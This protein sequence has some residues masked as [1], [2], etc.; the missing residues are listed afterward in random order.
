MRRGLSD[1]PA[2][3]FYSTQTSLSG[4]LALAELAKTLG[5]PGPSRTEGPSPLTLERERVMYLG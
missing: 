4:K 2:D 3:P 5:Q 1:H